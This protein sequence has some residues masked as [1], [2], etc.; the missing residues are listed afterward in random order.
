MDDDLL[1]TWPVGVTLDA[2]QMAIKPLVDL[3]EHKMVLRVVAVPAFGQT[4]LAELHLQPVPLR[5]RIE[6]RIK[7]IRLSAF[8]EGFQNEPQADFTRRRPFALQIT[9]QVFQNGGTMGRVYQTQSQ[10]ERIGRLRA[11][12]V[13]TSRGIEK[14]LIVGAPNVTRKLRVTSRI[15]CPAQ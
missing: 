15:V 3:T 6:R 5:V 1:E 4:C 14:F 2:G 13:I 10:R 7:Q 8:C 9:G 11:G 12:G